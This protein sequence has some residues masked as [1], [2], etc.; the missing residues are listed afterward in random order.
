MPRALLKDILISL[1]VQAALLA[2]A[3]QAYSQPPPVR[4]E[5]PSS[6]NPVGSGAR[7][8]D[9][10]G[11]FIAVADDA[12]ATSWN[13]GGLIQ[14][15]RPEISVVGGYIQ[16]TEINTFGNNPEASG[17]QSADDID[18]NYLS[19]AHPFRL[20]SRNMIVSLNYQRL[21][22][23]MRSWNISRDVD[24]PLFTSAMVRRLRQ[25]GAFPAGSRR[26]CDEEHPSR[27]RV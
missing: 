22:D 15:E 10:G 5:I 1:I 12:T 27:W 23:F 14:L 20:A 21:Y 17:K 2:F 4:M 11:A 8:L 3:F 6:F 9:M 19:V 16:R 24:N 18:L 25:W 26:G 7:A 13:P